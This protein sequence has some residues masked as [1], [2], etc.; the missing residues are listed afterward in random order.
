MAPS[1]KHWI[2]VAAAGLFTALFLPWGGPAQAAVPHTV[3]PGETIWSIAAANNLTTRTVASFNGLSE[4]AV[5][6]E[7]QTLQ[8]P[9]VAEGVVALQGTGVEP[10]PTSPSSDTETAAAPAE[11][12]GGHTVVEGESLSTIAAANGISIAALAEANAR[13]VDSAV[14]IGESLQVPTET[15]ASAAAPTPTS[16]SVPSPYGELVLDP[17]AA[18]N[19]NA[20]RERS[21]SD[22]GQDIYPAGPVSAQRTYEQ[23]AQLY[24]DY[25]NGVG[26]LAA[27]PGTSTHELGLSVDLQTPEMR[28]VIDQIGGVFG[29]GKT[30]APEEWW[31]VSYFGP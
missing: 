27:P 28:S 31:H 4:E 16:G 14:Y 25:L 13:S 6:L 3:Q 20:M 23:Q 7:G 22:Y 29:W 17:S 10:A 30:E 21:I 11:A 8:V 5:V 24:Q 19:W 26:P 1:R 18:E 2:R 15:P 9:T 12:T